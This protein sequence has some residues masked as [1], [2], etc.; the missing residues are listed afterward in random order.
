[1]AKEPR[2]PSHSA[3]WDVVFCN[4][5][6]PGWVTGRRWNLQCNPASGC[7]KLLK[8]LPWWSLMCRV[9]HIS[10]FLKIRSHHTGD[11]G[12]EIRLVTGEE[13]KSS[14]GQKYKWNQAFQ[15]I[16]MAET[17]NCTQMTNSAPKFQTLP[18]Y[19]H[20]GTI[21]HQS[22]CFFFFMM[23]ESEGTGI[24]SVENCT[25]FS[26]EKQGLALLAL[27]GNQKSFITKTHRKWDCFSRWAWL[28]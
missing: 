16:I 10:S 13:D 22:K 27:S 6:S 1:M 2:L 21:S 7:W 26:L 18:V 20:S 4:N 23:A 11:N 25:T 14:F 8:R 9:T 17:L 5:P 24:F 12:C 3:E 28:C 15:N 19:V